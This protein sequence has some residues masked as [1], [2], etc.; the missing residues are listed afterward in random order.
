[1]IESGRSEQWRYR[2]SGVGDDLII[3]PEIVSRDAHEGDKN[4]RGCE[5]VRHT[6]A[7]L[8]AR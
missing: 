5:S 7:H 6:A 2:T 1:M 3:N 8:K 4:P